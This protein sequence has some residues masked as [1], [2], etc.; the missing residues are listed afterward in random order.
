MYKAIAF[1]LAFTAVLAPTSVD[2]SAVNANV[3]NVSSP[4]INEIKPVF[5]DLTYDGNASIDKKIEEITNKVPEYFGQGANVRIDY[6]SDPHKTLVLISKE[7]VSLDDLFSN[8]DN[9]D[10]AY[11]KQNGQGYFDKI[12]VDI[13]Y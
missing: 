4:T 7:D 9:F 5:M 8:L 6:E 12:L 11:W 1:S 13:D 10:D 2:A 3:K